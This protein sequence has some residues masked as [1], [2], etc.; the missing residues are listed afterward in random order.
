M[1]GKAAWG[2]SS[3]REGGQTKGAK[4][5]P[6]CGFRLRPGPTLGGVRRESRPT[7]TPFVL[8]HNLQRRRRVHQSL[9]MLWS[10]PSTS[11]LVARRGVWSLSA[12]RSSSFSTST[13][14]PPLKLAIVG[15]GPSGL[16]SASRILSQLH[17]DDTT[18]QVHVYERL[19][20]PHGLVRYGV[21][22]D[23]PEVKVRP[24]NPMPR[25]ADQDLTNQY[26]SSR[27]HRTSNTS[28]IF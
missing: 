10:F 3:R 6:R 23:H 9:A 7:R 27:I 12:S 13:S 4:G 20:A 26:F 8:V 28:S 16:Y 19:P 2:S 5:F 21:A 22:P 17:E 18:S 24:H 11:S 25:H 1:K 14:L 15:A